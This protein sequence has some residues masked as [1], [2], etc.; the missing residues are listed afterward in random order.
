MGIRKDYIERLIEQ[1]AAALARILKA[2]QEQRSEEA[3]QLISEASRT[4]LG[5]EYGALTLADA[6]STARL[7]G[8]PARVQVLAKLVHQEAEVR[9][10]RGD[11]SGSEDRLRLALELYLEARELGLRL[12]EGGAKELGELR[13]KVAAVA[14]AERYQRLLAKA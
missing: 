10:E 13:E 3:L 9:R 6:A 7:L 14:L 12:D 1:F 8:E 2:R 5:M 4:V 11:A